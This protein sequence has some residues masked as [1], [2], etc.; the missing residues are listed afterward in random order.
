MARHLPFGGF[1]MV[2]SGDPLQL[3]PVRAPPL[4]AE[5]PADDEHPSAAAGRHLWAAI[6][7]VVELVQPMRQS[8]DMAFHG[9]LSRMRM[10]EMT[11]ADL[12]E[13]EKR[14][15]P[16]PRHW[17]RPLRLFPRLQ[18]VEDC[19]T[20]AVR[21]QG[22][23]VAVIYAKHRVKTSNRTEDQ[24]NQAL[25]LALKDKRKKDSN[26]DKIPPARLEL[27]RG[28]RVRLLA[29][30]SVRIGLVNGTPNS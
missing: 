10:G 20:D 11:E 7:D 2:F 15:K 19:N 29:N 5:Q 18:D 6:H 12:K 9:V 1:H 8:G 22:N 26:S 13:I 25:H 14:V 17:M 3:P 28:S 4:L 16:M 27:A 21:H 24:E 23:K 30:E